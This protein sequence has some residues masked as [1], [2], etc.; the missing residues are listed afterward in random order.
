MSTEL[1]DILSISCT[2]VGAYMTIAVMDE[3]DE[4][5]KEKHADWHDIVVATGIGLL[6]VLLLA[7]GLAVTVRLLI[8]EMP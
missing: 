6:S 7:F 2:I 3:Y 1:Q 4:W 5:V 8:G